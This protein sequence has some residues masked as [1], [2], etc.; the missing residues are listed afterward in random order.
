MSFNLPTVALE[1]I[2]F[3][4]ALSV[5]EAAHAW[6][7]WRR[8]D[9]TAR[10]LGRI[11]LNPI[12]HAEL[13]GTFLF[14]LMMLMSGTGWFFGWAKPTPVDPRHFKRPR[15]DDVLVSLAGPAS[16]ALLAVAWVLAIW[17]AWWV[18]PAQ[19]RLALAHLG[20]PRGGD[21][22][23]TPFVDFAYYGVVLNVVLALFNLIPLPPLDGSH[24]LRQCLHGSWSRGYARL[25][26]NGWI[27]LM[28]LIAVLYV[29]IPNWV[30]DPV[31]GW[32]Q[33][34]LP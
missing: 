34:C 1:L 32:F 33:K 10:L 23:W 14:P 16:N 27:S 29:G 20:Q 17:L 6:V 8:G 25:Y 26:H 30:L 31:L 13:F 19:A 22:L 7:A 12:K 15:F 21:T 4:L 28:L 9:P 24:V 3:L 5:H 11:T 18:A 2:A